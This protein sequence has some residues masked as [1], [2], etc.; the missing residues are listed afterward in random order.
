MKEVFTSDLHFHNY[1]NNKKNVPVDEIFKVWDQIEDYCLKNKIKR[2]RILGDTFHIRGK[3]IVSI[4]NRVS[5]RFE[6]TTKKGIEICI[7]SGN[8]DHIY[9]ENETSIHTLKKIDG[10]RLLDNTSD[11]VD[12]C[13]FISVPY[14][15]NK[16]KLYEILDL[17]K[18]V[19]GKT[20]IL[21]THG[22]IK[23]SMLTDRKKAEDGIDIDKLKKFDLVLAGHI[24]HPQRLFNN[25]GIELGSP[26]CHNKKDIGSK[27]RGFWVLDC[28]SARFELIPTEHPK[29]YTY[30]IN[31]ENDLD[32]I[33]NLVNKKDYLF[34][35]VSSKIDSLEKLLKK[36]SGYNVEFNI[37]QKQK[38]QT[39]LDVTLEDSED[40]IIE[41][42]ITKYAVGF[43]QDLL[44]KIS[45]ELLIEYKATES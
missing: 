16:N 38:T 39:R 25:V 4:F 3:I 28:E 17:I 31:S 14:I 37:E 9:D 11:I 8:H 18:T 2:I 34:L 10:I 43:N 22:T 15:A 1:K 6:E 45:S 5:D 32:S 27:Q 7:L 44:H 23:N 42:Y 41:N 35:N 20:N 30:N 40:K 13:N 21:L 19:N 26:L 24:H 29:F 33:L 36:A 12:N